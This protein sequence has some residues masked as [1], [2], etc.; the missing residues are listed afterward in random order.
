MLPNLIS[1]IFGGLLKDF[2]NAGQ[3]KITEIRMEKKCVEKCP[4]KI[5]EKEVIVDN[6][7]RICLVKDDQSPFSFL[8]PHKSSQK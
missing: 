6:S 7:R 3:M 1:K 8:Q 4:S 2:K 5:K